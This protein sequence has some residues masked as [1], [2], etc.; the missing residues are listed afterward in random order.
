VTTVVKPKGTATAQDGDYTTT[1]AYDPNGDVSSIT[2]PRDGTETGVTARI[3]YGR[4]AVGDPATI[5]DP[6]GNVVHNTFFDTGDLRSTDRPSLWRFD[7]Q[8]Q[9][10]HE[11]VERPY[12]EWPVFDGSIDPLPSSAGQ[13]DFGAVSQARQADIVPRAGQT[14]FAYDGEMRL[15]GVTN[16][17]GKTTTLGRDPLGR[18]TQ[19]TQP[20]KT[21]TDVVTRWRFDRNGNLRLQADPPDDAT[22]PASAYETSTDY[23]QFDRWV[24]RSEPGAAGQLDVTATP[25]PR[26]TKATWDANGN[27]LTETDPRGGV[28][29]LTYDAVDRA[30]SSTDPLNRVTTYGYDA[31]GNETCVRRPRGNTLGSRTCSTGAYTTTRGYDRFDAVASETRHAVD[32]AGAD[33]ALTTTYA[34]DADGNQTRETRPGAA[35]QPGGT[36]VTQPI[37]RV[38]DG[39]DQLWRQ[40][41]GTGTGAL[42][43]VFEH[44]PNGN[45]RRV[46]NPSGVASGG[47]PTLADAVSGDGTPTANAEK[48][49][50]LYQLDRDNQ[51]TDIW[52][53]TGDRDGEDAKRWHE[54]LERG[55]VGRVLWIDSPYTA[56]ADRAVRQ[57]YAYFDNGWIKQ[58]STDVWITPSQ[59]D[60]RQLDRAFNYDYTPRGLQ[61]KW[62]LNDHGR[63]MTRAYY[64]SGELARRKAKTSDTDTSPRSYDYAYD[65]NGGLKVMRDN[66]QQHSWNMTRD[67]ADQLLSVNEAWSSGKDTKY[68]YD[69]DGNT[70]VRHTDGRLDVSAADGYAGGKKTSFVLD[71]IGREL[72]TTVA[73]NA[74]SDRVTSTKWWPSG[75]RSE[76]TKSNGT[77]ERWFYDDQGRMVNRQRNPTSGSGDSQ[78]YTY[79]KAFDGNRTQDERG[80]YEYNARDQLTKWTRNAGTTV[81]YDLNGSGAITGK[82]DGLT[83]VSYSVRGDRITSATAT[84]LGVSQTFYFR[85]DAAGNVTCAAA[86]VDSDD[87][88]GG[89]KYAYDEFD[90]L[91]SAKKA[92]STRPPATYTYDG[93]DRR[94]FRC[95]DGSGPTCTSSD[96]TARPV[97]HDYSYVGLSE[98]LSAQNESSGETRTYDYDS[99]GERLGTDHLQTGTTPRYRPYATDANG[100]V[101]GLEDD[102]GQPGSRSYEYDPYG[103]QTNAPSD[104]PDA[105][106][107]PFRFEGFSYDDTVD[108]YDMQARPYSPGWGRFLGLDV[109]EDAAGD[110]ALQSDPLTNNRYAFTGGNPTTTWSSTDTAPPPGTACRAHAEPCLALPSALRTS[111]T[112]V[113][114]RWRVRS[115]PQVARGRGRLRTTNGLPTARPVGW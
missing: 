85:H 26:T 66:Q 71:S 53:P 11:L 89:D 86:T 24:A 38:F 70:V 103:E 55:Q 75:D 37:T 69:P 46:V 8:A 3:T 16:D 18:I 42:T 113:Q 105:N 108:T 94:D 83:D 57:S 97:K 62:Q 29:K 82:H 23:D 65:P 67:A 77:V 95:T 104:D 41:E 45:L 90:R 61:T 28:T 60:D 27:E 68:G 30:D 2:L 99:H 14:S 76:R 98:L 91:V 35:A 43:S 7:P 79:A 22:Y 54:H 107:N 101:V 106:D 88:L 12:D 74:E 19:L 25:A 4:N 114:P 52:L 51:L 21:G 39:R 78:D 31:N 20:F 10:G 15:Q 9:D 80:T 109:F 102:S 72:K 111:A 73:T 56:N 96:P 49:A 63:T 44:D 115:T 112:A 5:T 58:A 1:Y 40:T 13:G 110:M 6:R 59:N 64:P 47:L 92:S 84:K 32:A 81:T 87:C 93:L 17:A 36:V 34:Y 33:E 48:H 100:S 50:T